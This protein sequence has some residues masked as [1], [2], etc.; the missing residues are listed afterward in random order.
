V[1]PAGFI[2][3]ANH[4]WPVIASVPD[5]TLEKNPPAGLTQGPQ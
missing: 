3:G 2:R 1:N 5:A 4:N